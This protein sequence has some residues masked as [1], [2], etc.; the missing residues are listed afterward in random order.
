MFLMTI[1]LAVYNPAEE[2]LRKVLSASG[3][4]IPAPGEK[5][6]KKPTLDR[7]FHLFTRVTVL[8]GEEDGKRS[9]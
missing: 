1:A 6:M 3:E 8:V 4:S 7:L 5:P 2:E 9:A